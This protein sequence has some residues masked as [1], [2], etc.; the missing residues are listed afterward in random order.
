[1]SYGIRL[2]WDEYKPCFPGTDEH[3]RSVGKWILA[4][5]CWLSDSTLKGPILFEC[6]APAAAFAPVYAETRRSAHPPFVMIV[7]ARYGP[8]SPGTMMSCAGPDLSGLGGWL[9]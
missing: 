3:D 9:T 6:L 2:V 5:E 1:V 4:G 7:P 8:T